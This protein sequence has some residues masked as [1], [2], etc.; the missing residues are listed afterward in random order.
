[1]SFTFSPVQHSM[2]LSEPLTSNKFLVTVSGNKFLVLGSHGLP[3]S[4]VELICTQQVSTAYGIS[5]TCG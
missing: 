5:S 4:L 2:H 3:E 1:M